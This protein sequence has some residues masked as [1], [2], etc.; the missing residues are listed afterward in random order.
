MAWNEITIEQEE[1]AS[2]VMKFVEEG[3][4]LIGIFRGIVKY[5]D[6]TTGEEKFFWKFEDPD[7]DQIE[8]I[9]FPSA[10]LETK[11]SR[12]PLDAETKIVYLGKKQSAKNKSRFYKDFAIFVKG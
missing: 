10:V 1:K 9:V 12:V 8:F 6:K 5:A 3:D 11:M 4:E 2:S 7:D